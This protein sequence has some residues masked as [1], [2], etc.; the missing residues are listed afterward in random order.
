LKISRYINPD[1]NNAVI[2]KLREMEFKSPKII[3]RY[4]R[5]VVLEY[6]LPPNCKSV[7]EISDVL[8]I[9]PAIIY[10]DIKNLIAK[11]KLKKT[12][13]GK[14]DF[15]NYDDSQF[16]QRRVELNKFR[17]RPTVKKLI[18]RLEVKSHT[19]AITLLSRL[20]IVCKTLDVEPEYLLKNVDILDTLFHDFSLRLKD[21]KAVG[22]MRK[23]KTDPIKQSK[24]NPLNYAVS[25]KAYFVQNGIP[26]PRGHLNIKQDTPSIFRDVRLNDSQLERIKDVA[27]QEESNLMTKMFI[28]HHET[29]VRLD[30]LCNMRPVFHRKVTLVDGKECEYFIVDVFEKKQDELF[31][32]I[33][34]TPEGREIARNHISGTSLHGMSDSEIPTLKQEYL[35]VLRV[36]YQDLGMMKSEKEYDRKTKEWYLQNRSS[37]TIRH[38]SVHWLMRISGNNIADVSSMFWETPDTLKSYHRRS[39]DSFLQTGI[40]YICKKPKGVDENEI[41]FCSLRHALYFYNLSCEERQKI[42]K[43]TA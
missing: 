10:G 17:E 21:G 5:R 26:I 25:L 28:I 41:R 2:S 40:C 27:S 15:S 13:D 7:R 29:G 4:R 35:E 18:D 43:V 12:P 19:Y 36:C 14:L 22:M 37:H 30:T 20:W 23:G 38:S 32:K 6:C 34:F 3:K 9:T 1:K 8:D 11:G 42:I 31:Q 16:W 33:I 39:V 24:V